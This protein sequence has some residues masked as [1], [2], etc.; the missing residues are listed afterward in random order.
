MD[1]LSKRVVA[2]VNSEAV[3]D[4][5]AKV[6]SEGR[7]PKTIAYLRTAMVAAGMTPME[8]TRIMPRVLNSAKWGDGDVDNYPA[9]RRYGLRGASKPPEFDPDDIRHE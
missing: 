1:E 6:K 7:N 3:R 2:A 5:M 8:A 4:A 9:A